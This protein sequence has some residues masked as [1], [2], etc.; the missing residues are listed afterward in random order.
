MSNE[1][2]QLAED[3][4]PVQKSDLK[5]SYATLSLSGGFK[6]ETFADAAA[7]GKVFYDSGMF[8]DI[9]SAAQATIKIIV[10]ATWGFGPAASI[11]NV[12]IV[13]GKFQLGYALLGA[14]VKSSIGY[15]Y[16]VLKLEND[17]VKLEFFKDGE[18]L[19]IS[20]FSAQDARAAGTGNM[21]KYPRNM[22]M[23][24]ALSNGM[25]FYCPELLNGVQVYTEGEIIPENSPEP[26][27]L[28][29][30]ANSGI[31]SL[32]ARIQATKEDEFV[33]PMADPEVP[34]VP[35]PEPQEQPTR[36]TIYDSWGLSLNQVRDFEIYCNT[37][38]RDIDDVI[39][40][41]ISKGMAVCDPLFNIGTNDGVL[42]L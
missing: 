39:A 15:D 11:N 18:S 32:S 7:I 40:L 22:L 33:D 9:K 10:G 3:M 28:N 6:P 21:G 2:A 17:E 23:A 31:S 12:H 26:P 4:S 13:E 29:P 38:G 1:L 27:A 5:K 41:A 14:I 20:S 30:S 8:K 25:K 35:D 24:R 19:G 42:P 34:S 36:Q 16:K 37:E